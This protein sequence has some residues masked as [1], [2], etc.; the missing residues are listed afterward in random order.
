MNYIATN[1]ILD[2]LF[3]I[4][5]SSDLVKYYL[6]RLK[7]LWIPVGFY[8]CYLLFQHLFATNGVRFSF[9][10]FERIDNFALETEF[11]LEYHYKRFICFNLSFS[12][13]GGSIAVKARSE[14][15]YNGCCNWIHSLLLPLGSKVQRSSLINRLVIPALKKYCQ[16]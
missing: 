5:L 9:K 6:S 14:G 10:A 16:Y 2:V 7:N 12:F 11:L 15:G 8:R 13:N 3:T 1:G 4:R